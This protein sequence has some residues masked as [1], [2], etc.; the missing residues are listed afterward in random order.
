MSIP[1]KKNRVISKANKS[2]QRNLCSVRD[3]KISCQH[4]MGLRSLFVHLTMLPPVYLDSTY[5][6]CSPVFV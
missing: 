6:M 4:D 1:F 5:E 3:S 2:I